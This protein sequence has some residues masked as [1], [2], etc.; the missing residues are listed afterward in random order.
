MNAHEAIRI[1][2]FGQF[3][4][5]EAHQKSLTVDIQRGVFRIGLEIGDLIDIEVTPAVG[6]TSPTN[7]M[8]SMQQAP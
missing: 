5:A 1:E 7:I 4:D 8:I 3:G 2:P 6:G